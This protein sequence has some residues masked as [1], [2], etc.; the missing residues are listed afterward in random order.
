VLGYAV[1]VKLLDENVAKLLPNPEPKRRRTALDAFLA[2]TESGA[3]Q[4]RGTT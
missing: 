3:L 1:R 4:R 2:A